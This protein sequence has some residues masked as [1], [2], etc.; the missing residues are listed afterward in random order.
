MPTRKVILDCDTGVD[1]ALALLLA[2]RCPE[3]DV[4]GITT[5]AGNVPIEKVVRNTLVVVEAAGR[6][7][8]VFKGSYR[9]MLGSAERAEYAHGSDGLGDVGFPEPLRSA[10]TEHAVD[11]LVRTYMESSE[12]IE[13]ITTAPLTN[14]ALALAKEPRLEECIPSIVMMA[15]GIDYGNST[16]AAEFNV[17]ADPEAADA[18]LRSRIRTKTIVAY[19]PILQSAKLFPT[20]VEQLES[21]PN[22]WRRMAALLLRRQLARAKETSGQERPATPPDLAA[23]AYA[24]D[25]SIAHSQMYPVEVETTG[26]LTRGMTLVD[27]RPYLWG[28]HAEPNVNT[29]LEFD[30]ERYRRLVLDTWLRDDLA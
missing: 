6:K 27:R 7:T 2:L 14:I 4:I 11:Y 28:P 29:I 3:L 17:Y 23:V 16:P 12:P 19:D 20:D 25:P 30:T 26:R 21:R 22:T 5:V 8:P 13:L 18:V 24:I 15:G 1:D 10:Q 9:A